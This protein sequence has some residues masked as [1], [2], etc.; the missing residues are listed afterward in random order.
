MRSACNTA[1]QAALMQPHV[2]GNALLHMQFG[3]NAQCAIRS[4]DLVHAGLTGPRIVF[5]GQYGYFPLFEGSWDL[6]PMPG[7][8][9][10][11]GEYVK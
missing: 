1:R 10:A 3:F 8:W 9:A 11:T 7:L 4:L 6:G 5:E 2:E